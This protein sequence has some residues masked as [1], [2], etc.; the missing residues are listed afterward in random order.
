MHGANMKIVT[1]GF[2]VGSK[3]ASALKQTARNDVRVSLRKGGGY[4][5]Y[6][7]IRPNDLVLH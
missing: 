2:S 5:F 4:T 7:H 1:R 3:D 6:S